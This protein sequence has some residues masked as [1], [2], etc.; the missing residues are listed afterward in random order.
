MAISN[1]IDPKDVVFIQRSNDNSAYGEVHISGSLLIFYTD[2]N[3]IL[4]AD[5]SGS[6]YTKFPP[7]SAAPSP[8]GGT[9]LYTASFYEITSS[10]ASHSIDSIYSTSSLFST[11]SLSSDTST[12]SLSAISSSWASESYWATSSSYASN[13]IWSISSSFSSNSI[14]AISSSWASKSISSSYFSG[15]QITA[16]SIL[17]GEILPLASTI[18]SPTSPFTT[19]YATNFIGTSSYA[20]ATISSSWTSQSLSSSYLSGS[21]SILNRFTSSTILINTPSFNSGSSLIISQSLPISQSFPVVDITTTWSGS[22]SQVFSGIRCNIIDSGSSGNSKYLDIQRSGVSRFY[23]SNGN[24][25]I[26]DDHRFT[27]NGANGFDISFGGGNSVIN[28][29]NANGIGLFRDNGSLIFGAGAGFSQQAT[30]PILVKDDP[31]GL[32]LRNGGTFS[33]PVSNSFRIYNFYSASGTHYERTNHYWSGSVYYVE[34]GYSASG[35]PRDIIFRTSGSNR[36]YIGASGS[37]GIGTTSPFNTLDVVG[38]I[39]SSVVTS[40]IINYLGNIGKIIMVSSS[41]TASIYDYTIL[42]SGSFNVMLPSILNNLGRIY[43][44]KKI[45]SSGSIIINSS[46]SYNIDAN[47][48]Y[49]ISSQYTSITTQAATDQWYII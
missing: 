9:T 35:L 48:T 44:I 17:V 49:T 16:S 29:S 39:S 47:P 43:N 30:A 11:Q 15:S 31:L 32:A 12:S 40:S 26:K 38:N 8:G 19:I 36:L 18:G 27:S 45:D 2:E 20:I 1:L 46:Q 24:I 21:D 14:W 4:T 42:C 33:A 3:G 5:K 22:S 6:F 37:I 41:Y 25:G 34:T 28:Y 13:S 7:S 23:V 10:W